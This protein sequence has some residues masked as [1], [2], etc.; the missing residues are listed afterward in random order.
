MILGIRILKRIC[1][2]DSV[3]ENRFILA[4]PVANAKRITPRSNIIAIV[5]VT[6]FEEVDDRFIYNP[7]IFV[8]VFLF[9]A[10]IEVQHEQ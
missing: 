9:P 1:L 8:K 3:S 2:P 4:A 6:A 10:Q 5:K 7:E